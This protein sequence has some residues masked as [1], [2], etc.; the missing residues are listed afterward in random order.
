VRVAR[1]FD[2]GDAMKILV[3]RALEQGR[4]IQRRRV[5]GS[6]DLHL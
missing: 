5:A 4:Q 2:G 3:V 6:E 1:R